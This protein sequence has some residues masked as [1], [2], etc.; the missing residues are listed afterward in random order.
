MNKNDEKQPHGSWLKNGNQPLD[1]RT[2]PQCSAKSKSTKMQCGNRAMR[3]KR[4]CYLHGGRSLGAPKGNSY[5]LRTGEFTQE[6]IA[7]RKRIAEFI[8]EALSVAWGMKSNGS[9]ENKYEHDH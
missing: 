6:G 2:L 5:A 1:L 3:N 8:E 4:V 9:M 7:E